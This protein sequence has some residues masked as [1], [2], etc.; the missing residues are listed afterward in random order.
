MRSAA[1]RGARRL[2]IPIDPPW[3]PPLRIKQLNDQ[4]LPHVWDIVGA[5]SSRRTRN[6]SALARR[7]P[8]DAAALH[9]ARGRSSGFVLGAIIGIGLAAAFVHSRLLER[10][11]VPVRHRQPDH[12]DRGPGADDRVRGSAAT[13]RA[14]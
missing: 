12:P 7:R 3:K 1:T 4:N 2:G 6:E 13:G 10:A 11:L 9:L 14:S 8:V 5:L